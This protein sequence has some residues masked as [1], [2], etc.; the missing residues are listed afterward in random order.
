MSHERTT[1]ESAIQPDD[2]GLLAQLVEYTQDALWMFTPDWEEL[3]FVNSAYEDIFG[4]SVEEINEDPTSFLT[5]THPDDRPEVQAAMAELSAGKAVDLEFRVDPSEDYGT[6]VWVQG[7]PV[8]DEDGEIES[9]AGYTRDITERK[10]YQRE[11]E[12]HKQDLKRSNQSLREFAYIASHDLQE[13][14]RMVS[15]YVDLLDAEYGDQLDD[16][17]REYMEFAVNGAR[18]MK[19]MINSLLEYSRVHTEAGEFAQADAEAVV[20]TTLQDLSLLIDERDAEVAVGDLPTVRADRDQ[21]AQVFQNLVKN[22]IEHADDESAPHIEVTATE[23]DSVY[24]FAVSDDGP[25]IPENH[26]SEIFKIFQ[27][28]PEAADDEGTGIGLAITQRIVQRHGGMIQ[29]ESDSGEGTTFEFTLPKEPPSGNTESDSVDE[30][31]G[32]GSKPQ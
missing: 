1:H 12:R 15:S 7:Q 22:A 21:L 8:Y 16:E 13:P 2:L 14:L 31:S 6:W 9:V 27:Q 24:A 26:Q 11:L 23:R 28:D 5:S 25:G 29:V 17:A 10:R 32:P 19:R 20:E 4:H 3:I 30:A 18:R